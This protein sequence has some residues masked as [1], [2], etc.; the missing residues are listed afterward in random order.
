MSTRSA[1]WHA[2]RTVAALALVAAALTSCGGTSSE[3]KPSLTVEYA[4]GLTTDLYLPDGETRAPLVVMVPGGAWRTADPTGL[5]GLAGDLADAG[6]AAA[7]VHLRAADDGAV[8][9]EPVEEVLCAVGAAVEEMRSRGVV[10]DPVAVLGHSSGAQLAALAVLA[11]DH[12]TPTCRAPAVVPDAL[13]GLSGPYDISK[14]PEMATALMGSEPGE[15][16]AAWASAN[17]VDQAGLRPDVPV[18][19]LH[20]A[21]DDVVPVAFTTQFARALERAGHPTTVQVVPRAGHQA[22]Y[23]ADVAGD[24]IEQWLRTLP[25]G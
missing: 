24:R 1:A 5:T 20:G 4:R 17:P 6:I 25:V 12:R 11:P 2:P 22:I 7:T 8:Y 3:V 16:P 10:P 18:L 19:L 13:I 14:V 15:D 21:A 23:R 9:P